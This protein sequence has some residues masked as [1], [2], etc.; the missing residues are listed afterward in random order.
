MWLKPIRIKLRILDKDEPMP[1]RISSSVEGLT[2][3]GSRAQGH[4]LVPIDRLGIHLV[5]NPRWHTGFT[6][7]G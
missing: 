5:G 3:L 2:Q 4:N 7:L 6:K 1:N